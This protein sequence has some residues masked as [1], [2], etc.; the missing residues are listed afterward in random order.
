[1]FCPMSIGSVR[2][3][4]LVHRRMLFE[5]AIQELPIGDLVALKRVEKLSL[6]DV[7]SHPGQGKL[8]LTLAP[9]HSMADLM[10]AMPGTEVPNSIS[11]IDS[12]SALLLSWIT[13]KVL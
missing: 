10:A 4:L 5:V 9:A 13:G 1:M 12:H 11:I 2:V 3:G 6:S 7:S 8:R